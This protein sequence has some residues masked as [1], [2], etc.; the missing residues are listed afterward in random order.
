MGREES[1]DTAMLQCFVCEDNVLQFCHF[2]L[3]WYS[4][5]VV[6][7][8]CISIRNSESNPPPQNFLLQI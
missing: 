6:F 8:E 2:R 5:R 4:H 7:Y 3:F 1:G